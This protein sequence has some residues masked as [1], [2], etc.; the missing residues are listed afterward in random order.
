[1]SDLDIRQYQRQLE[2]DG[3]DARAI[4]AALLGVKADRYLLLARPTSV[5]FSHPRLTHEE[6]I[7]ADSA[8]PTD[9]EPRWRRVTGVHAAS[10]TGPVIARAEGATLHEWT[11]EPVERW[12]ALWALPFTAFEELRRVSKIL[13]E[14][15]VESAVWDSTESLLVQRG[16]SQFAS[17]PDRI[18]EGWREPRDG[19]PVVELGRNRFGVTG[20]NFAGPVAV[21]QLEADVHR[22]LQHDAGLT[23]DPPHGRGTIHRFDAPIPSGPV[24]HVFGFTEHAAQPPARPVERLCRCPLS[25]VCSCDHCS[26]CGDVLLPSETPSSGRGV[27]APCAAKRAETD[28]ITRAV[29]GRPG[30]GANFVRIAPA[31][32]P[33]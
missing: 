27:C 19:P 30:D 21:G 11:A 23:R 4:G 2:R 31:Q 7:A 24:D 10:T 9:G 18:E 22:L 29:I 6:Q 1:M 17:H 16:L 14:R 15:A 3:H 20:S 25:M 33:E 8:R 28:P 32:P 12:R 5:R 26:V 13:N